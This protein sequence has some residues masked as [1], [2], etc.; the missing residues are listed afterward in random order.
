MMQNRE[1]LWLRFPRS[2]QMNFEELS[3]N[4]AARILPVLPF[5]ASTENGIN[6][7]T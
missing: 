7:D 5:A 1:V 6:K 4:V 2:S 3:P